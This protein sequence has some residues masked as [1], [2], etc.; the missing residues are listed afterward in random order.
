ME[1]KIDKTECHQE[2]CD[3][4]KNLCSDKI[5]ANRKG[6]FHERMFKKMVSDPFS[7]K[8]QGVK[9]FRMNQQ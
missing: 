2:K 7:R 9:D 1:K 3:E 4:P 8:K 5:A 6:L